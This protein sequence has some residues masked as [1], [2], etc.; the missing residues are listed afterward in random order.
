MARLPAAS[1]AWS[2]QRSRHELIQ[3]ARQQAQADAASL[4]LQHNALEAQAN[5]SS[6][7]AAASQSKP[8]TARVLRP[9]QHKLA[10][11]QQRREQRQLLS[12]YDDRIQTQQQL[13]G[14]YSKWAAQVHAAASHRDPHDPA[15]AGH[16]GFH[17][18]LRHSF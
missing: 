17:S 12:I 9:K 3:Q 6:A 14:V 1:E 8:A 5:A 7:A 18:D 10:S 11:L 16:G 4:T 2:S 15:V 13:A